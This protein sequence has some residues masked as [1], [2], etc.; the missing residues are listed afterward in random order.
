MTQEMYGVSDYRNTRHSDVHSACFATGLTQLARKSNKIG[1]N[2]M[3]LMQ[4]GE[5]TVFL[6]DTLFKH[7]YLKWSPVLDSHS[8]KPGGI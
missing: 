8:M 3:H 7:I 6:W 1:V 5:L 4:V 2:L